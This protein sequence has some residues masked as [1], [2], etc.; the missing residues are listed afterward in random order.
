[1]GLGAQTFSPYTLSYNL[2]AASKT[3]RS[4]FEAVNAGQL[5]IQDVYHLPR[6]V[7]M[8][9]M[10]AV[11]F[12]F[13]QIH[14]GHFEA[15]FGISLQNQFPAQIRFALD[16]GLMEYVDQ[17]LRLTPKGVACKS[18]VIAL[19]YASAVQAY[20][21]SLESSFAIPKTAKAA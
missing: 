4:Y 19:F 5:P 10:I 15:R 16:E 14:C 11:S 6:S 12:Y 2:G 18:G 21:L 7:A 17:Y 9:K 8:A 1:L 13:G 3:L 20:L